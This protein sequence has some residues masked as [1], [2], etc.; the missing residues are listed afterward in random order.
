M[1]ERNPR[2]VERSEEGGLDRNLDRV[3][4]DLKIMER[5]ADAMDRVEGGIQEEMRRWDREYKDSRLHSV[6]KARKHLR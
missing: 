1:T 2:T 4:E 6:P 3:D 5:H